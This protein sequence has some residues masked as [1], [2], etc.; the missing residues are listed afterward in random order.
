MS[1]N[2]KLPN[3]EKYAF[4]EVQRM[5]IDSL[6]DAYCSSCEE[7]TT[8]LEHDQDEGHCPGCGECKC[9]SVLMLWGLV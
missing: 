1:D 8:E 3:G 6:C 2:F 9:T 4:N 5:V 7:V